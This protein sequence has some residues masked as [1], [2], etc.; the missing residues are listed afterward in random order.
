[1]LKAAVLFFVAA[2]VFCAATDRPLVLGIVGKWLKT[3]GGGEVRFGEALQ[4][5]DHLSCE[6]HGSLNIVFPGWEKPV[7]VKCQ[8]ASSP[9]ISV[10]ELRDKNA[11]STSKNISEA[12]GRFFSMISVQFSREPTV[13]IAAVSRAFGEPEVAECVMQVAE[14]RVDLGKALGASPAGTYTIVFM[15]V[16]ETEA[17]SGGTPVSWQPGSP[18][19]IAVPNRFN[20]GGL[21]KIAIV[22]PEGGYKSDAWVLLA[23]PATYA[24]EEAQFEAGAAIVKQWPGGAGAEMSRS[25]LRAYLQAIAEHRST[26]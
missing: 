13:Y 20:K 16:T 18:A 2:P 11:P 3:P 26:Q 24:S 14:G 10:Q 6:G 4:L 15:S 8:G 5:S 1:M 23:T 9:P 22:D 17:A 19:V 21:T 12:F 25:A 7:P